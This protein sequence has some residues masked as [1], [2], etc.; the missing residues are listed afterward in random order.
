MISAPNSERLYGDRNDRMPAFAA[1]SSHPEANL[2]S[3]QE[4][5]LLVRWMTAPSHSDADTERPPL[6]TPE[7]SRQNLHRSETVAVE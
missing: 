5:D 4:L 2:M 7:R 1:D 3:P 6:V